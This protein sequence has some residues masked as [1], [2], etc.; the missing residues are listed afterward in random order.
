V[1]LYSPLLSDPSIE[2]PDSS[3]TANRLAQMQRLL[4]QSGVLSGGPQQPAGAVPKVPAPTGGPSPYGLPASPFGP[5]LPRQHGRMQALPPDIQQPPQLDYPK[6][7]PESLDALAG[8]QRQAKEPASDDV[9]AALAGADRVK[10]GLPD[11]P[12]P[13]G[14]P[15]LAPVI[16]RGAAMTPTAGPDTGDIDPNVDAPAGDFYAKLRGPEGTKANYNAVNPTSGA[17]G[18]YQFL[19]STWDSYAKNPKLGLT[20]EGFYHPDQHPEQHEAA[21]HAYTADSMDAIKPILGRLPT[22]GELYSMHLLGQAGGGHLLT[23]LSKPVRETVSAA[24]IKANPW[25][26]AY[27]DTSGYR[28]V[29]H[30][31]NMFGEDH[32]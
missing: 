11:L 9:A 18:P 28:L 23:N 27:A 30:F 22:K 10:R 14:Q 26:E 20:D 17:S 15:A 31:E 13:D 24:A 32:S 6:L 1:S 3:D 16:R 29:K 8:P 25:M 7:A 2:F 12:D 19:K 21:I 5:V 4:K